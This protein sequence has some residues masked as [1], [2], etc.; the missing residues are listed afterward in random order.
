MHARLERS[1][2]HGEGEETR[3][4]GDGRN[5]GGLLELSSAWLARS[6]RRMSSIDLSGEQSPTQAPSREHSPDSLAHASPGRIEQA[7]LA[8][9][10]PEPKT[11][12]AVPEPT[13]EEERVQLALDFLRT[14]LAEQAEYDWMYTQSTSLAS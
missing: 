9:L 5:E 11:P 6:S 12:T 8:L 13:T 2:G 10:H 4:A 3:E 14:N 1:G 7:A